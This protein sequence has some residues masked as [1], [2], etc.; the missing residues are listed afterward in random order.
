M[1]VGVEGARAAGV[2]NSTGADRGAWEME[3]RNVRP[4]VVACVRKCGGPDAR[5]FSAGGREGRRGQ[6][7]VNVR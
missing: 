6:G 1:H 4:G 2:E 5:V 7:A 3:R